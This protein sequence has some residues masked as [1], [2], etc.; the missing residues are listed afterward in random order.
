MTPE[1]H[2]VL[3]AILGSLMWPSATEAQMVLPSSA[4]GTSSNAEI[5]A[6]AHSV[7]IE[8]VVVDERGTPLPHVRV[9]A[10]GPGS[11]VNSTDSNGFFRLTSLP[12]GRYVVRAYAAGY[13]AAMS[14]RINIERGVSPSLRLTL[15]RES[16]PA[17]EQPARRPVELAAGVGLSA[18]SAQPAGDSGQPSETDPI[19]VSD[20]SNDQAGDSVETAWRMR[21]LKRTPLK[22]VDGAWREVPATETFTPQ[23]V[24]A[25]ERAMTTSAHLAASLFDL[26][27]T[28]QVNLLTSGT[29]DS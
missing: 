23:S 18:D 5:T 19:D 26:S 25:L 13:T 27:L 20:S 21:H 4:T 12:P 2:L 1:R 22:D 17:A 6:L 15:L 28:G 3:A 16:E 7:S 24:T 29:F 8:G 11:T 14:G 9:R 10:L